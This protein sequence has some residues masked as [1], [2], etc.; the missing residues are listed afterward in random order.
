MPGADGVAQLIEGPDEIHADSAADF[1]VEGQASLALLEAE[2]DIDLRSDERDVE[3]I[4]GLV[5]DELGAI[6]EVGAMVQRDGWRI[7][8]SRMTGNRILEVRIVL[9]QNEHTDP[10]DASASAS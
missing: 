2:L 4:A 6:P 9:T 5:M 7:E 10:P 3:S 1:R 8:V